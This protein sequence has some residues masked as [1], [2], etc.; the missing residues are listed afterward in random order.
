MKANFQTPALSRLLISQCPKPATWLR[1]ESKWPGKGGPYK[2]TRLRVRTRGGG[3]TGRN[4]GH[5]SNR[6][7]IP[8][9]PGQASSLQETFSDFLRPRP[10]LRFPTTHLVL[11]AN[12]SVLWTFLNS[13]LASHWLPQLDD[14]SLEVRDHILCFICICQT[15]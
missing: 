1:P 7:R 12:F 6:P 3:R 11:T 8:K 13:Q 4:W 15:T 10:V 2:V 9:A 5:F 14:K